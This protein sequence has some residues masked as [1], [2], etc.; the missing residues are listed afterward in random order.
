MT[1][2]VENIDRLIPIHDVCALTGLSKAQIYK[3]IAAELFPVP[4]RYSRN[5]VRW[6]ESEVVEWVNEQAARSATGIVPTSML[7]PNPDDLPP[8]A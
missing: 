1:T 5:C 7:T 3:L 6:I 2:S 8:A 4:I